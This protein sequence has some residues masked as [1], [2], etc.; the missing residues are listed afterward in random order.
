MSRIRW[1]PMVV[2]LSLT[3]SLLFGGWELYRNFG[4]VAPLEEQLQA[5]AAV[6]DVQTVV[7]GQVREVQIGLKKVQ[8]L[9]T[10]YEGLA[11]TVHEAM[12]DAVAIDVTD[13]RKQDQNLQDV[14][15]SI[16]P[17]LYEGISKGEFPEMIAKVE[18]N[19]KAAGVD[20]Q[21]SMNDKYVFVQLEK[22][23]HYLYEILPYNSVT[24]DPLKGVSAL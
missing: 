2:S 4:L 23:D 3:L 22:G 9:Q 21:I 17:T 8:D 1:V 13:N 16:Q 7:S 10:T 19:T 20:G 24:G 5:N 14:Y 18:A 15:R 6:T 12:G 11:A